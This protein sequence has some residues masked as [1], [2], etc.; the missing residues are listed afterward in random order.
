MKI[1]LL[2]SFIL[3]TNVKAQ[4]NSKNSLKNSSKKVATT[5]EKKKP[6]KKVPPTVQKI[7][8]VEKRNVYGGRHWRLE[9][10]GKGPVH[11]WIP[12]GYNRKRG[13]G[14]VIYV[15]GYHTTADKTWENHKLGLQF[16]NSK[17]NAM[18]VVPE[19]PQ[20]M[21][22]GVVWDSLTSLKK[23]I[24]KA[25]IRL[26]SGPTIAIGHSG[27]FRTIASW[28]DNRFLSRIIL[29]DAMYGGQKAWEDFIT[30]GKKTSS[31]K[32]IILGKDTA[33]KGK[34]FAKKFPR[35]RILKKMPKSF[36]GFPESIR[37]GK[38]KVLFVKTEISHSAI[39]TSMSVIPVLLRLTPLKPL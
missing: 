10:P 33:D 36:Y 20:N 15:H 32:L 4:D 34:S 3:S 13:A 14:M 2:I 12:K 19:A 39:V 17:Q 35:A 16:K 27:A 9:V 38:F 5:N 31:H 26:P 28:V 22:E 18:F 37:K 11:V 29:L 25:N 21:N 1:L 24:Q 30:S 7:K 23:T 6:T 8:K